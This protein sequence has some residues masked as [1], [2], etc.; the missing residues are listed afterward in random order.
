MLPVLITRKIIYTLKHLG[1]L[2]K[3]HRFKNDLSI[4]RN[5]TSSFGSVRS[6]FVLL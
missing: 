6:R 3:C 1:D 5:L 4:N 2:P